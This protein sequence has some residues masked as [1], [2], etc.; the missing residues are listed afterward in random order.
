MKRII[1]TLCMLLL[2]QFLVVKQAF[3][4]EG[5]VKDCFETLNRVTFAF[6]MGLD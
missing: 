1:T 3:G 4:D 6:N 5:E 2:L